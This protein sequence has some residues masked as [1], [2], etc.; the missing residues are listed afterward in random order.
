MNG[1]PGLRSVRGRRALGRKSFSL[2]PSARTVVILKL[3]RKR[4]RRVRR[5]GKLRVI[6]SVT[7]RDGAGNARTVRKRVMLRALRTA[8]EP[9]ALGGAA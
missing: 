3:T 9:R 4:A 1:S 2:R 6:L 5:L 7:A 8:T